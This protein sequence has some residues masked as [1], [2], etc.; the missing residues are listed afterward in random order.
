MDRTL[1]ETAPRQEVS[2][3]RGKAT[4][5]QRGPQVLV[6][7][8]GGHADGELSRALFSAI[9]AAVERIGVADVFINTAAMTSYD[10]EMRLDG[11]EW[12]REQRRLLRSVHVLVRSPIVKMGLSVANLALGG[13]LKGHDRTTSFD[14][15][16][17][18]AIEGK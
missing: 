16:L 15:A 7:T 8:I 13:F 12:V 10:K 11:V 17:A 9:R 1:R 3:E 4:L 6:V 2:A 5:E 14:R 18:D